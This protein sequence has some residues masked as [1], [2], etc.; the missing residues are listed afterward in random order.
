MVTSIRND[1]LFDLPSEC[2]EFLFLH[3]NYRGS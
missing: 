1:F 3:W 2:R